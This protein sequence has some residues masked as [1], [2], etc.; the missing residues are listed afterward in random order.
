[1]R[2]AAFLEAP[3]CAGSPTDGSQYAFS[4]LREEIARIWGDRAILCPMAPSDRAGMSYPPNLKSL[5]EVCDVCRRLMKQ[6][7]RALSDGMLPI[8][9]GGDHSVAMG[10]IAAVAE[11]VGKENLSVLWIDGHTDINTERTTESGCIHGMPLAQA[12]GLCTDALNLGREKVHLLGQNL[13]ILGARSIDE[14]EWPI[15][16]EQGVHLIPM[17]QIR[18]RGIEAVMSE[19]MQCI[20]TPY[21]HVSFDVDCMDGEVFPATGYRMPGGMTRYEA[22]TA[23]GRAMESGR[24]CSVDLVE[25]NPL[26]D[27]DG[28]GRADMSALLSLIERR[29]S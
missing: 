19:V 27:A 29:V 7:E 25:Y 3:L 11:T 6:A 8:T 20:S 16:E 23:M 2:R 24:V 4:A 15:I 17:A 13:F 26:L 1:V 5:Q 22:F 28:A 12:L 9:M 14:G 21:L 10:S 18:A